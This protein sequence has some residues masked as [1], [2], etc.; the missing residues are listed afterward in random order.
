METKNP[1]TDD[2]KEEGQTLADIIM[3]KLATGD[4]EDGDKK[5]GK[6]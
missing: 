3:A 5:G 6:S 2:Q 4:Y 1:L